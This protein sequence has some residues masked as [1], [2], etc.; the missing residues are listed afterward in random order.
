MEVNSLRLTPFYNSQ[1]L[2]ISFVIRHS[3]FVIHHSSLFILK[4]EIFHH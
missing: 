4:Y 3:S 1:K 2:N